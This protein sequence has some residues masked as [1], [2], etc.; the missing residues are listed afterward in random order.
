[1][2]KVRARWRGASNLDGLLTGAWVVLMRDSRGRR[3][4]LSVSRLPVHVDSTGE[5]II[6]RHGGVEREAGPRVHESQDYCENERHG[7]DQDALR[8][9]ANHFGGKIGIDQTAAVGCIF[10]DSEKK[11]SRGDQVSTVE[12]DGGPLVGILPDQGGGKRD[13]GHGEKE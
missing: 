13:E 8:R 11:Q 4:Q 9:L 1:M 5:E 3:L 7:R 2:Q 6:N 12:G 10:P